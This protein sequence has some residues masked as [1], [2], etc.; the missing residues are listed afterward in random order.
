MAR[1]ATGPAAHHITP[2]PTTAAMRAF[3]DERIRIAR[4]HKRETCGKGLITCELYGETE[5]TNLLFKPVA[6][7]TKADLAVRDARLR[8]ARDRG[9]FAHKLAQTRRAMARSNGTYGVTVVPHTEPTRMRWRAHID[10]RAYSFACAIDAA[11][12]RN[13][14]MKLRYPKFPEFQVNVEQ[15][16][17][18]WGCACGK[19]R[20]PGE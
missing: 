14:A 2:E 1:G 6:E 8:E 20:R 3:Y 12:C 18:R 16:W 19:H 9:R 5:E 13:A 11:E 10:K 4:K 17:A 15:I 7:R